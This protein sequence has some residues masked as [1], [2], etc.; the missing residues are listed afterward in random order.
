[1]MWTKRI[2]EEQRQQIKAFAYY[3]RATALTPKIIKRFKDEDW[4]DEHFLACSHTAHLQ[5]DTD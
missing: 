5:L 2:T 4:V 1:M 3:N